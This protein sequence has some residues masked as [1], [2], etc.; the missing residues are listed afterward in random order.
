MLREPQQPTQAESA[1]P[2]AVGNCQPFTK[3]NMQFIQ[4]PGWALEKLGEG[5][6]YEAA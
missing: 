1:G 5:T 4:R 2:V 6:D 3:E